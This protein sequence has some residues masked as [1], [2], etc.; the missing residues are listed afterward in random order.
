MGNASSFFLTP[1]IFLPSFVVT[2]TGLD[3]G[4]IIRAVSE[5]RAPVP[6]VSAPCQHGLR[7]G[8]MRPPFPATRWQFWHCFANIC[9]PLETL[10]PVR[11]QR[12]RRRQGSA[13]TR[14][15]EGSR[16]RVWALAGI[17]VPGTPVRIT[18]NIFSSAAPCSLAARQI[19]AA[20]ARGIQT[21]DNRSTSSG[22]GHTA[23]YGFLILRM[24]VLTRVRFGR[25]S[26]SWARTRRNREH[27]QSTKQYRP[28]RVL[29]PS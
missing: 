16:C 24:R 2:V 29:G 28:N 22:Q 27:R 5:S 17:S 19:G 15:S 18:W 1:R 11:R 8:P 20:V 10:R 7:S 26:R 13:G 9:P 6:R 14:S 3:A 25:T 4:G 23:A 21:G 12:V